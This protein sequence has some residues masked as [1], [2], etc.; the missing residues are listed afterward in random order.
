MYISV[1]VILMYWCVFF[2][3]LPPIL[4]SVCASTRMI[5]GRA[6]KRRIVEVAYTLFLE[7]L[8][9]FL[10]LFFSLI[11]LSLLLINSL[12]DVNGLASI[13]LLLFSVWA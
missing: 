13:L 6:G 7:S 1:T 11:S 5:R 3:H 9:L 4:K 12:V 2:P 10:L 8:L